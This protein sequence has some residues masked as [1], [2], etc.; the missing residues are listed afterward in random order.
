VFVVPDALLAF[1]PAA[2]AAWEH[3]P[4]VYESNGARLAAV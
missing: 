4:G 1:A 3:A 2:A